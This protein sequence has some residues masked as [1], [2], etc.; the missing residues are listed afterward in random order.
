MEAQGLLPGGREAAQSHGIDDTF[1][2]VHGPAFGMAQV[3]RVHRPIRE[4]A[5]PARASEV[6]ERTVDARHETEATGALELEPDLGELLVSQRKRV[7]RRRTEDFEA[8]FS[9]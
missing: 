7:G 6:A 1:E 8:H 2:S 3:R 9:T 5:D 4:R